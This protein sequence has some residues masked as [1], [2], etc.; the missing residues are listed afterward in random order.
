MPL[1]E[2]HARSGRVWISTVSHQRSIKLLTVGTKALQVLKQAI[3]DIPVLMFI[4]K[5]AQDKLRLFTEPSQA[6]LL[7]KRC[8]MLKSSQRSKKTKLQTDSL[9]TSEITD[10]AEDQDECLPFLYACESWTL[11]AELERRIQA[12]EMIY[13]RRLLNITYKDH[14]MNGEVRNRIQ[15]AI[16]KDHVTNREVRNRIHKCN[17]MIS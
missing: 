15:N 3:P 5:T 13:Y 14:V 10:S 9:L 11:T 17:C 4:R 16:Y 6:C 2:K 12:H 1:S 7:K 8:T